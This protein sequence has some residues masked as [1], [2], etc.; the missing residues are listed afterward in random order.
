MLEESPKWHL[1]K[2]I[3]EE[4]TKEIKTIPREKKNNDDSEVGDGCHGDGCHGGV[5][6]VVNDERTCYQL[7][8]VYT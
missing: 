2:M 6:V 8:Q 7:K 1:L 4:V 5:L 3:L